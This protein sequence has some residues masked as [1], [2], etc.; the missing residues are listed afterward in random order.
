[1]HQ[2]LAVAVPGQP[3]V[4]VPLDRPA[5]AGGSHADAIHLAGLPPG[6]LAL[7][8]VHAGV[9][10]TARVA[11]ARAA[12]HPLSPGARRLLRPG[13]RVELQ[14]ASLGP[15]A[16]RA[17]EGTRVLAAA[18]LAQAAA[19]EVPVAGP[20]LVVLTGPDAGA[21]LPLGPEEILGRSRA[22]KYSS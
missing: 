2:R 6:A 3:D 22:Q 13:E 9:V 12:G 15:I 7:E 19:G 18:L 5:T 17:A 11:G 14:G 4:E 20:H 8:P 1:M 10:A 16:A 21:R